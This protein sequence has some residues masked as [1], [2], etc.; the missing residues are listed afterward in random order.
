MGLYRIAI[1]CGGR[2]YQCRSDDFAWLDA[3]HEQYPISLLIHG[4]CPTGADFGGESWALYRKIP[5]ARF[6]APLDRSLCHE[7]R[8]NNAMAELASHHAGICIA[9]PGGRGTEI[10]IR[11][12][13]E[14]GLVLLTH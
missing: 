14:Y 4:G 6:P 11:C 1:I 8:R 3:I 2:D 13:V 9:F 5:I 10:M 7:P 12:A